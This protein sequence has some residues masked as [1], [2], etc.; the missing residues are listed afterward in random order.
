MQAR[1]SMG[2]RERTGVDRECAYG[3]EERETERPRKREREKEREREAASAPAHEGKALKKGNSLRVCSNDVMYFVAACCSVLQRVAACC[4]ALHSHNHPLSVFPSFPPSFSLVRALSHA[5]HTDTHTLTHTHTHTQ[6]LT[7]IHT[8]THTQKCTHRANTNTNTPVTQSSHVDQ[9][10]LKK[11]Q[12]CEPSPAS[13]PAICMSHVTHMK[14]S[15]HQTYE[16][17][18]QSLPKCRSTKTLKESRMTQT[19]LN[20]PYTIVLNYSNKG[21]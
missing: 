18:Q 11:A 9:K 10:R 16:I 1:K 3:P 17:D 15:S 7:Q 20:E 2:K 6:T 5:S 12:S 21:V 8:H 4:N 19:P 14:E 13:T